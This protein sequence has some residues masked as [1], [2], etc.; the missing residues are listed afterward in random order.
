MRLSLTEISLTAVVALS[1][2][3]LDSST[4]TAL[5]TA[6]LNRHPRSFLPPSKGLSPR[7]FPAPTD[8]RPHLQP[9]AELAPKSYDHHRV[10]R[11]LLKTEVQL[12]K[13][14]AVERE[15]RLDYFSHNKILGGAVDVRVPP[16][17]FE[18]FKAL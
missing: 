13:L 6:P 11:I 17:S 3:L 1:I 15:L 4:T 10:V 8:R 18:K 14:T 7:S 9:R 12:K 2:L 16:E 5:P